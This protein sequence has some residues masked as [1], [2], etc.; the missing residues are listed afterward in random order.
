MYGM[1]DRNA[2]VEAALD[3]LGL[4]ARGDQLA[5]TLSGGWKQRLA[6]S[7]CLLHEPL[8]LLLDEPTAGV[9]P[10]ARRE[11]WEEL[12]AFAATGITV[13]VSTHYMDEAERCHKLAYILNGRLLAQGTVEEVI[14][15]QALVGWSVEGPD[16]AALARDLRA[17]PGVEQI[18]AFGGRLHV[19]GRDAQRLDAELAPF[20]ADTRYR[21]ERV[22]P[23]LEDVFIHL[24]RN[25]DAAPAE[26]P[27]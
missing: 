3:R 10:E 4:A 20:R 6:L 12:H 18:A 11:F 27:R 13:L 16:L 9:D 17:L 14:A 21:W 26:N 19:V 5:G 15:G 25:A 8:L 22:Q 23:G 7:A 1:P 2:R 24:M